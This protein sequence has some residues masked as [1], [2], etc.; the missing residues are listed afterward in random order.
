MTSKSISWSIAV[1]WQ[2]GFTMNKRTA[3]KILMLSPIYFR[4]NVTERM[5]LIQEFI[6]LNSSA[7]EAEKFTEKPW[8]Q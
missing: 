4:L 3:V 6:E 1:K 7:F 8:E 2:G 5:V